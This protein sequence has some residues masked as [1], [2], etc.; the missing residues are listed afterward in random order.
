MLVREHGDDLS[1]D[2]LIGVASLLLLAGHE[3]TSNM[4]GLGTLA[5]LISSRGRWTVNA[6]TGV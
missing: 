1:T 5:L 4:L 2:E 6:E 3:T